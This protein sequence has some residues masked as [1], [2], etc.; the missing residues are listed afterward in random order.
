MRVA[1]KQECGVAQYAL[2]RCNGHIVPTSLLAKCES[3]SATVRARN[4]FSPAVCAFRVNERV[5]RA[6]PAKKMR[7]RQISAA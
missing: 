7:H 5:K 3:R 2:L 1:I 4:I 6:V